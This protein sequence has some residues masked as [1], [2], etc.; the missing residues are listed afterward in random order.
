MKV[1]KHG[2]THIELSDLIRMNQLVR[3]EIKSD[4]F[5]KWYESLSKDSEQIQLILQLLELAQ[6]SG[7]E[8]E[9]IE[10]T[11]NDYS[12]KTISKDFIRNYRQQTWYRVE[13]WLR[14]ASEEEKQVAFTFAFN[15]FGKAE[16]MVFEK[17]N[18]DCCNHWW[19]R[20][21]LNPDIVKSLLEDPEYHLTSMKTDLD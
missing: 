1:D 7:F 6:Q 19:H 13:E 4:E 8:N 17:E 14:K 21:L 2:K 5:Q 12:L 20:D 15:L 3:L 11:I 18:A 10:T 16:M 9:L